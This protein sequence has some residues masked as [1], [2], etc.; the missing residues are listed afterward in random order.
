M[1][2]LSMHAPFVIDILNGDKTTEYRSWETSYRGDILLCSTARKFH[3]AP[4]GYAL[5]VATL[6][7]CTKI[8]SGYAWH[9]SNV[10]LIKPVKVKG[11]QRIYN[12]DID[13]VYIS[14]EDIH[15]FWDPIVS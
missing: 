8:D 4:C 15:K 9:L 2:A 13:P 3:N 12:L 1:K 5:L 14:A 6:D 10:R 7:D 11:Q